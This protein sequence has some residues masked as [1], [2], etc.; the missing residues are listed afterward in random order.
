MKPVISV[1]DALA[2]NFQ[3]EKPQDVKIIPASMAANMYVGKF[4]APAETKPVP[5][6]SV[7]AETSFGK[8]LVSGLGSS[9]LY[10]PEQLGGKAEILGGQLL[11]SIGGYFGENPELVK[12]G[13]KM[14]ASG[15]QIL[16]QA[17]AEQ[18]AI[19]PEPTKGSWGQTIGNA[20]GTVATTMGVGKAAA[21]LAG[22]TGRAAARTALGAGMGMTGVLEAGDMAYTRTNKYTEETKDKD[23]SDYAPEKATKNLGV[24]LL[25]GTVSGAIE[26]MFGIGGMS[27]AI[28]SDL[29]KLAS[30]TTLGRAATS[31]SKTTL[32]SS[33]EESIEEMLQ[34]ASQIGF[35]LLDGTI[36]WENVPEELQNSWKGWVAAALVGGSIG[37]GGAIY[38]RSAGIKNIK[39]NLR[40]FVPD[41]ELENLS[42]LLYDSG[43]QTM[44]EMVT[45]EVALNTELQNK[46]GAIMDNMQRAIKR[47]ADE[48]GAFKNV[49]EEDLAQYVG[50]TAKLFADQVLAEAQMRN[51]P[52]DTVLKA[53]DIVYEDGGIRLALKK[54]DGET[55]VLADSSVNVEGE[56]FEGDVSQEA[57][58]AVKN[59]GYADFRNFID[60]E[61]NPVSEEVFN[62]IKEAISARG[63]NISY[64]ELMNKVGKELDADMNALSMSNEDFMEVFDY[65]AEP[66][67]QALEQGV[68]LRQGQIAD[69]GQSI[70]LTINSQE[71]MQG[72]SNEDFKNKMLETLKSFKGNKIFNQSLNGDIEIRTSS[73]KKYKSFFA[74][75]NKRLI[76][77]YIPELLGKARFNKMEASYVPEKEPNIKAY[78]KA[79]LPINI[80]DDTYNVHLTVREDQY[81]NFFWDAQIN[82][83]PQ[84]ATPATNPGDTGLLS[85]LSG[86]DALNITPIKGNVKLDYQNKPQPKGLYDAN[87]NLI[88]IFESADF[89]TL[90]HE[91]AHYWLNN[92][93]NYTRSGNASERY[94]Q[95]WNVI[96]NWLGITPEQTLITRRQQEKFARGYEQYLLNG[97]L[98]TPII[99]GAFDDYDRWLKRVYGDMNRLNVRLSEDAVRFF[100]SMT[101]G[102]LP[103]PKIKPSKKPRSK[104]TLAEKLREKAGIKADDAQDDKARNFIKEEA[105]KLTMPENAEARTVITSNITEGEKGRSRVYER[106]I[107]R[108]A[109]ELQEA[110]EDDLTYNKVN[111]E[112]QARRA[113]EFVRNNLNEARQI[114]DGVKK[115]PDNILDTAIR[116]AY[117]QEMLRIGNQDEYLRALKLHSGLQTLRG[118]EISAERISSGDITDPKF[119]IN[120][121]IAARTEKAARRIFK[122]FLARMR[123]K[124]SV[125]AFKDMIKRETD[126]IAKKVLTESTA[127]GQQRVLKR[128]L[129]RLRREY[130]TG[131]GELLFQMPNNAPYNNR[132]AKLYV[133]EALDNLFGTT[134]SPEE[135]AKIIN[136]VDKL[137]KSLDKTR[138]ETGNPT[139]QTWINLRRM[140]DLTESMNPSS[141]LRIATSIVGRGAM[142]ASVK[143][144]ILNITSNIENILTEMMVRRAVSKVDGG[145][146][147]SAVDSNVI[148]DYLEYAKQVYNASGYNLSTSQG[149][150]KST[151][152]TLGEQ[153]IT[154]QGRGG[155]RW[156]ARGV[157]TGVFKYLM[158]YSDSR[159]KDFVFCDAAALEA[160]TIAMNEGL[161]GEAL[162]KRA[163]YL[164]KDAARVEPLTEEGLAI[165]EKAINE[166]NI[167]TYTN[168][169]SLSQMALA[170]RE[171]LN[172]A[173]GDLRLGDQLMPFVK[174]PANVVSLGLEYSAGLAYAIPNLPRIIKDVKASKL[175]PESRRAIKAAV[176]NGLGL[177]L[178]A[179]IAAAFDPDDYTPE[180]E[181]LT[182][183]ER[184]LAMEKNAVFNSIRIGNR[185]VSLDYFG[186]LA[187]PLTAVLSAKK[188]KNGQWYEMLYGYG[189]GMVSQGLKTPGF[190]ELPETIDS[191]KRM[192]VAGSVEKTF[193]NMTNF[194]ID[195]IRART[196]P[197]IIND[198][199]KM[200]D[201]YERETSGGRFD[202]TIN[203]LPVFRENLPPKYMTLSKTPRETEPFLST[204]FFGAR[205]KTPVNNRV[206][207]EIDRLYKSGNRVTI[208]D[209]TRSGKLSS[210]NEAKQQQVR[211]E[212]ASKYY[213]GVYKLISKSSYRRMD[214][215]DKAAEMNKLRRKIVEDLKDKYL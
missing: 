125:A 196:I 163:T 207:Y 111:L 180:Y 50:D 191:I 10:M 118:Q 48:S 165:R 138:D 39:E 92:M 4:M 205:L 52:I 150:N 75:K 181:S 134:V 112:E 21:G 158:G 36:N 67:M 139:L 7:R 209:V 46:H 85:G 142:L 148:K 109:A 79:D 84:R 44:A 102:T 151:I 56:Q 15:N 117:E 115:A 201:D 213:D 33:A 171:A 43:A 184:R 100:Q 215:E 8:N 113:T 154:T 162:Q 96:A 173:T 37:F 80:D 25:H 176:R 185:Y 71:E 12:M 200:T 110:Y 121:V 175:S 182:P 155:F 146:T 203:S 99:K 107:E 136:E 179:L 57:K 199:A 178:A 167:A 119:W 144:P 187:F 143:S 174:T 68:M 62:K 83:K 133:R 61:S 38:N 42:S 120:K 164:F 168:D 81:G 2:D 76:V 5:Y 193:D 177:I 130:D 32:K 60:E 198:I 159:S 78:Y 73:I 58:V 49:S 189:E 24:E 156:F 3:T 30:R 106:E 124:S 70:E 140:N 86:E 195:F 82:E 135:N 59:V 101:T 160:T 54:E 170:F 87:R 153:R 128:E 16:E 98:P 208:T 28:K 114:I 6:E 190:E 194:F 105:K 65:I 141:N 197:S 137:E 77:P 69:K 26:G 19:T 17:Y 131:D 88:K 172:N 183:S 27:R 31:I 214:D 169:T 123:V 104:M 126:S 20:L 157:E 45:A 147:Y 23:F 9:I 94:Q 108:T 129:E 95:R 47:A 91:L 210:L 13:K 63:N 64:V 186:P 51:E 89:S 93:W 18:N 29:I 53:S 40:G 35:N 90:P 132:N 22:L 74:D 145:A 11:M 161:S 206:V 1:S 211:K 152:V 55:R 41:E 34:S 212:F 149:I 103:P 188:R 122:S 202:R 72:L 127:E 192:V 166:A 97:N 66:N 204:L 116:I 14:V